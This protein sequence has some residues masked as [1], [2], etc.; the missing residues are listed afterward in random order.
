MI[1][2]V[3]G[4]GRCGSSLVM[5]MLEAGGMP[6]S[7]EYPAFED[8]AGN[9]LLADMLSLDYMQ[10]L[11]GKAVKLLDPHRGKIPKGP[12]YH[13]LG[14]SRDYGEQARSQC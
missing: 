5:Q 10:T 7:G 1:T 4:F 3:S 8:E 12:E 11:E 9:L 14:C 13:V 6:C 2:I